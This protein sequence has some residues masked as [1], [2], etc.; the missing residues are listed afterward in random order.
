MG[1]GEAKGRQEEVKHGGLAKGGGA[2]M[3][4]SQEEGKGVEGMLC[5]ILNP[6]K[7][8]VNATHQR[9]RLFREYH[10]ATGI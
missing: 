2:R 1:K 10:N 5:G 9:T 3:V 4:R 6:I 8:G 7:F